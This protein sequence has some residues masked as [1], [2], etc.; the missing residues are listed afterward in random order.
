MRGQADENGINH[1]EL[2][3]ARLIED[4]APL[5]SQVQRVSDTA[6]GTAVRVG[7]VEN[8]AMPD[9]ETNFDQL[10]TNAVP[11]NRAMSRGLRIM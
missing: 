10:Q 2:L 11:E 9:E 6:K 5:T 7:M 8:V 4:M 3:D 1:S